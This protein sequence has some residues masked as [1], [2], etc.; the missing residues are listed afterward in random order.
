MQTLYLKTEPTN[1]ANLIDYMA[2][3]VNPKRPLADHVDL[4]A[5]YDKEGAHE[6]ARWRWYCKG[7]RPRRGDYAATIRGR[8]YGLNWL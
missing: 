8:E 4:V 2:R 7:S 6:V 5:Y 1:D 3:C